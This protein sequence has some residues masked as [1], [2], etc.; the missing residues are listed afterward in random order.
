MPKETW[1]AIG[2]YVQRMEVEGGYLYSWI[3]NRSILLFAPEAEPSGEIGEADG[4]CA[5][6]GQA[7]P[8]PGPD[9]ERRRRA[10][11]PPPARRARCCRL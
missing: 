1:E 4:G 10:T 8:R 3:D 11:G 2:G 9:V 5:S 7:P 6:G